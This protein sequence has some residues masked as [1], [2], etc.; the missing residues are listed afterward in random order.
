MSG[1]TVVAFDDDHAAQVC[2]AAAEA[3]RKRSHG[4]APYNP[5]E[6]AL[7]PPPEQF[8]TL[9]HA[10]LIYGAAWL[11]RSGKTADSLIRNILYV[12]QH[13]P[14]ILDPRAVHSDEAMEW[15]L[16]NA[17]PFGH[18][19]KERRRLDWWRQNLRMLDELYDADPRNIFLT[20]DIEDNIESIW[21]ARSVLLK[22]LCKFMG[23]QHKIA[24]LITI[25]FQDIAWPEHQEKWAL[26]RRIPAIPADIWILRLM[27]QTGA[28]E[29]VNG[30]S[31]RDR[32]SKPVAEYLARLCLERGLN[33]GDVAQG[34]WHTGARIDRWLPEDNGTARR[35][36]EQ[37][38]Y[39]LAQCP[40][41]DLCVKRVR[42][43]KE[44]TNRGTIGYETALPRPLGLFKQS[45]F[46]DG[47][48]IVPKKKRNQE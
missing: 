6:A 29:V 12:A 34:L 31:H 40:L 36:R 5:P 25:W 20:L 30:T 21:A 11:Q 24:Q 37:V 14:E 26:I 47:L 3:W 7:I 41:S 46:P 33:H 8:G 4:L 16:I 43:N 2:Q 35:A 19:P 10:Y 48:Q 39:C 45:D 1:Q 38:T 18:M 9:K 23:V 32:I 27:G 17:I 13:M 28:V 44:Q 42:A 15:F 22:R